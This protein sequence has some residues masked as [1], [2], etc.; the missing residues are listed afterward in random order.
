MKD[1]VATYSSQFTNF[2]ALNPEYTY[3]ILAGIGFIVAFGFFK[4]WDWLLE[5][6]NSSSSSIS[7]RFWLELVGRKTVRLYLAFLFLFVSIVCLLI[8]VYENNT[9]EQNTISKKEEIVKLK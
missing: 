6:S 2:M 9:K 8:F 1:Q 5:T 7:L 4:D 3:L